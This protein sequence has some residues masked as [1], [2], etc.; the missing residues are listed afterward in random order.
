MSTMSVVKMLGTIAALSAV[1]NGA[2]YS[3]QKS[4]KTPDKRKFYF[5]LASLIYGLLVP[6]LLYKSLEYE[7]IGMVNFAWNIFS[8]LGGFALGYYLFNENINQ[9]QKIGVGVGLLGI[10]LLILGRGSSMT[11]SLKRPLSEN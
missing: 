5:I 11:P 2:M 1:E 6:I 7:G 8:T 4:E 10:G 9:L 3:L